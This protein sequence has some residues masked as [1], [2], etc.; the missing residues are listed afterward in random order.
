MDDEA[1]L[2]VENW[3]ALQR[4]GNGI[5]RNLT[6]ILDT[7]VPKII[8]AAANDDID[9]VKALDKALREDLRASGLTS[10]QLGA[11][12]LTA[13][14]VA[15]YNFNSFEVTKTM[16][17]RALVKPMPN[18]K[19][20]PVN[21]FQRVTGNMTN[22]TINTIVNARNQGSTIRDLREVL[23][24]N[25]TADVRAMEMFARTAMNAVANSTKQELYVR[26]DDLVRA[27]LWNSVLDGRT[28]D[29][30]MLHD[31]L[32]FPLNEGPRPPAH[33]SCRSQAVPVLKDETN[34]G[35]IRDLSPRPSITVQ[36]DYKE[37]DLFT[38]TGK[39]RKP[40]KNNNLTGKQV[41][42]QT[43]ETWLRTQ[44]AAYQNDILGQ[45]AGRQFR[46]GD[47]LKKVITSRNNTI[48]LSGLNKALN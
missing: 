34:I 15:F 9:E 1:K 38:R 36:K 46:G 4:F 44:P 24:I 12:A 23:R 40:R 7:R 37:G 27:V 39:V 10:F 2:L 18:S 47:T 45:N 3:L 14:E 8:A 32:I 26:N 6:K 33:P 17:N 21:L 48:D 5:A 35:A 30:C 41:G 42:N 31:G 20:S 22:K 13:R 16:V 25:H 19:I 29:F 43:Y 11:S 28:S